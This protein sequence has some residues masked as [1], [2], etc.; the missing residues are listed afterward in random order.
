MNHIVIKSIARKKYIKKTDDENN[1]E[2]CAYIDILVKNGEN[3]YIRDSL[4]RAFPHTSASP[5]LTTN[6]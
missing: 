2:V 6:S 5:L 4:Q 1:M 3:Q